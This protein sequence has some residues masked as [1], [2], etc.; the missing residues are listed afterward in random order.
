MDLCR[1]S[2]VSVFLICCLGLSLVF[3]QGVFFNFMSAIT[4]CSDFGP[5]ENSLSLFPFVSP[6]IFHEVMGLES[7]TLIF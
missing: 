3:F 7:M 6:S 4:I 2:N 5:Q 1:Q